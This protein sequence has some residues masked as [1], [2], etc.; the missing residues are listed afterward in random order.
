MPTHD[1]TT[2]LPAVPARAYAESA[3]ASQENIVLLTSQLS[4]GGAERHTISL[5]NSLGREFG[6]VMAYLKPQDD[7]IDS[8][9]R[10]SLLELR[11]LDAR[12]RIDLQAARRLLSLCQAHGARMIVCAN[13]F[14]LMHAQLAR[15]LSPTPIVVVEI[16]HT[17][18]LRTLKEHLE[19]AFYRPWFWAAHD[20]VFVCEAQRQ[21]WRWRALWASRTHMIYNGVDLSY[22]DPTGYADHAIDARAELGF[23]AGDRVVGICAVLRPEKAH[24]DLLA[25]VAQ[26]ARDGQHWKVLIIGDG[27]LRDSIERE[28]VRL[29]LGGRVRITGFQADVRRWLAACDAVA[30]VSTAVE[31]FSIAALE[32]MA[33]GKPMIMSDTGG[34]REQVEHGVNGMVFPPGDVSALAKCLSECWDRS[35]TRQM[36]AAARERVERDFSLQT[37]I[38]RYAALFRKILGAMRQDATVAPR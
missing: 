13:A 18:K 12:K 5:A 6:V 31:T 16:F 27:P 15:W 1:A 30:L 17:T 2:L 26:C 11:C 7:M 33:M 29:G 20:L 38:D 14:A 8:V 22:F 4:I 37:M 36:G 32:A 35:R 25:A 28:V 19:L 34:A 10:E 9:R 21:Y 24:A 23:E 3:R